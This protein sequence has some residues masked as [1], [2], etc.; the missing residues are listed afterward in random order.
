[1]QTIRRTCISAMSKDVLG[2]KVLVLQVRGQCMVPPFSQLEMAVF[3]NLEAFGLVRLECFEVPHEKSAC[4]FGKEP[5]KLSVP[6]MWIDFKYVDLCMAGERVAQILIAL[7]ISVPAA[8]KLVLN[9]PPH[10]NNGEDA[11]HEKHNEKENKAQSCRSRGRCPT[12]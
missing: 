2:E 5:C 1:M 4:F 10:E 11:H 8:I 7:G 9:L 3:E 6:P 12:A